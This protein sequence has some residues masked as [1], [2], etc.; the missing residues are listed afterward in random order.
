MRN[1]EK[2]SDIHILNFIRELII[3]IKQSPKRLSWFKML[4]TEENMTALRPFYPTRWTF[5]YS[6]FYLLWIIT[7]NY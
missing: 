6:S 2:A 5:R 1:V 3:F 4:Q 7:M